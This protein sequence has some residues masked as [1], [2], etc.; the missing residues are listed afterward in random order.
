MNLPFDDAFEHCNH[1]YAG[2]Q[3]CRAD[4]IVTEL[5]NGDSSLKKPNELSE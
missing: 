1:G 5:L 4:H 2:L 3:H